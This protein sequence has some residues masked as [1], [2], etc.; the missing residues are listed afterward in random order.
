MMQ[1]ARHEMIDFY[2]RWGT[3][4]SEIPNPALKPYITVEDLGGGRFRLEGQLGYAEQT[5][6][7]P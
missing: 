2:D 3:L 1:Q 7:G 4:P 5:L 6:E